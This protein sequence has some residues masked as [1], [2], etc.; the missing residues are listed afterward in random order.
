[1][2]VLPVKAP[3]AASAVGSIGLERRQVLVSGRAVAAVITL[4]RIGSTRGRAR[5]RWNTV[6]GTAQSAQHFR[7]ASAI[8]EF[9]DGQEIRTLFVPIMQ[10]PSDRST[11][12]FAVALE[13]AP[14]GPPV[15]P[16]TRTT[17]TILGDT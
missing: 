3:T 5:V 13:R 4:K 17:V 8:A 16:V 7:S 9:A 12:T 6:L 15:G 2:R 10:Q 1:M 14:G 11:R